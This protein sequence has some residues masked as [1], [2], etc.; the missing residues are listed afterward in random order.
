MPPKV[1]RLRRRLGL[2]DA[3]AIALGAI[4]G[5][6]IFVVL[7]EAAGVAGGT[8]PLAIVVAAL[9]ATLNGLSATQLGVSYPHAG[10]AY[11]FGY[12]LLWP[13]I[14]FLAGWVF[15]LSGL[16]ASTTYTL[17]FASYLQP[18][19]PGL[20]LRP[21]AIGLAVLAWL[22]NAVGALLSRPLN[23]ALVAFKIAVLLVFVAVGAAALAGGAAAV[24]SPPVW[25]G[26]PRGAALLFFAFSG[27]A[28]P[29]TIAEE[30]L[31]PARNLPRAV[32]AGLAASTI[33]YLAVAVVA[34]R[35]VGA[36]A[37]AASP[38]PLRA[39]L[40][41]TGQAWAATLVSLGAL[42]ATL[43]VLLTELWGLSRVAFAMG[44]RGDLPRWLGRVGPNGVPRQA[45]LVIGALVVLLTATVDLSP[46]LAASSLALL[47][48]YVVMNAAALRL[49]PAQRLYP[50]LVS[51]AGLLLSLAL[52]FSLPVQALLVVGGAVAAGL[53]YYLLRRR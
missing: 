5:A 38:A 47:V 25:G 45:V 34:S 40:V 4:I 10:G 24:A 12:R 36:G 16:A 46:A 23:N 9:A 44:R 17:T 28:R 21:L 18:L 51:V 33:L 35:L 3:T 8:L 6:G 41:P 31:D 50:R 2:I 52:A 7:G 14:G 13:V 1:P 30:V 53:L 19:L 49:R 26:L 27:Y 37:L 20:P 43:T 39:A 29:V 48:Y 32:I 11:E 15:L 42:V 22:A